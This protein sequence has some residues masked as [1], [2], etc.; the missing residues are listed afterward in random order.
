MERT[1]IF[2]D[3]QLVP[4]GWKE[5]DDR[6]TGP[7]GVFYPIHSKNFAIMQADN[8]RWSFV[9]FDE[10]ISEYP[11]MV[12]ATYQRA[13]KDFAVSIF[14]QTDLPRVQTSVSVDAPSKIL[15]REVFA[16]IEKYRAQSM[17][18]RE[19][20]DAARMCRNSVN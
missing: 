1:Q 11:Q 16:I 5:L 15:I 18:L 9:T 17:V 14:C 3:M 2:V 13:Y 4:E 10:F 7:D 19:P 8:V 12:Q 20:Q 6:L